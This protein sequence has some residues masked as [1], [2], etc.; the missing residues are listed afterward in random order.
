MKIVLFTITSLLYLTSCNQQESKKRADR[1]SAE[2]ESVVIQDSLETLQIVSKH[3]Q[4]SGTIIS[5]QDKMLL[6]GGIPNNTTEISIVDAVIS[7]DLTVQNDLNKLTSGETYVEIILKYR[8]YLDQIAEYNPKDSVST[9]HHTSTWILVDTNGQYY[10]NLVFTINFPNAFVR[11]FDGKEPTPMD[12]PYK[13][14][15]GKQL[16]ERIIFKIPKGVNPML[17]I[18]KKRIDDQQHMSAAFTLTQ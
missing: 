10:K 4:D 2:T 14:S 18:Y 11:Y 16:E 8:F 17:L 9:L 5:G 15:N 7:D 12:I 1:V 6:Q 13:V 3:M